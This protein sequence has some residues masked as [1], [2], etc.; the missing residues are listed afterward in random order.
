MAAAVV[1]GFVIYVVNVDGAAR[2]SALFA[3][4]LVLVGVWL[5]LWSYVRR[6]PPGQDDDF[7][8]KFLAGAGEAL[9]L[10]AVLSF[11]FGAVGQ[12]LEDEQK[13]REEYRAET[14]AALALRRDL[15]GQVRADAG[16]KSFSGV[17]LRGESFAGVNMSDFDLSGADLSGANLSGANLTNAY[18]LDA[19][20]SG[21]NLYGADLT[22]AN[23]IRANLTGA[24]LFIANLTGAALTGANLTD[25]NLHDAELPRAVL[26]DADLSRA[27]LYGADLTDADLSRAGLSEAN[28]TD[29]DL[30]RAGLSDANLTSANLTNA[31][32]DRRQADRRQPDRCKPHRGRPVRHKIRRQHLT[33]GWLRATPLGPAGGRLRG[34]RTP[35]GGFGGSAPLARDAAARGWGAEG[36][37]GP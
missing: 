5:L 1:V 28:L 20:L 14:Q 23:L 15:A 13:A 37:F 32:P 21:A 36:T 30:S 24:N 17:D 11:G 22:D 27:G 10:G 8:D 12:R 4:G 35:S 3:G 2:S 6:P 34:H 26:F 7:L 9:L 33:A 29:A 19:D 18:L 31:L 25:A 16:G